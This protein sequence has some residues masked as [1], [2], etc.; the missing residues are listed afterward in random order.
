MLDSEFLR[1]Y[2]FIL[3]SSDMSGSTNIQ[4]DWRRG[5]ERENEKEC[6][7]AGRGAG[8]RGAGGWGAGRQGAHRF[9]NIPRVCLPGFPP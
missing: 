3:M 7:S 2:N 9:W 1:A 6:V 8:G 5:G 4:N